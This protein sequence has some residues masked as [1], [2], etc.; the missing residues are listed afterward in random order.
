MSQRSLLDGM[1]V[2][3]VAPDPV[4]VGAA[5]ASCTV[6]LGGS[7]SAGTQNTAKQAFDAD[8]LVATSGPGSDEMTM[9]SNAAL[10]IILI[11]TGHGN[12]AGEPDVQ[13]LVDALVASGHQVEYLIRKDAQR[14]LS[15]SLRKTDVFIVINP[16]QLYAGGQLADLRLSEDVGGRVAL[17]GGSQSAGTANTLG[18]I[19]VSVS[20]GVAGGDA[21]LISDC[22]AS[23]GSMPLHNIHDYYSNYENIHATPEGDIALIEDVNEVAFHDAAPLSTSADSASPVL[24]SGSE[25]RVESIHKSGSYTVVTRSEVVVAVGDAGFLVS[26]SVYEVDSEVL[27]GN[28]VDFLVSGN[29]KSDAPAP[30]T[31]ESGAP[32]PGGSASGLAPGSAPTQGTTLASA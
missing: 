18:L 3:V 25:A 13:L 5:V 2:F 22:G 32:G 1:A 31:P 14:N 27:V 16:G 4:L 11:D 24:V 17:P 26:E 9:D 7:S 20:S 15:G 10:K 12:D 21:G 29:K 28:L 30:A 8:E 6:Q 19:A 23:S